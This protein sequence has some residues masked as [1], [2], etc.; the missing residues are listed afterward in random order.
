MGRTACTEPQCLYKCAVN[1]TFFME[2]ITVGILLQKLKT[3]LKRTDN[4]LPYVTDYTI[5]SLLLK[6]FRYYDYLK[7]FRGVKYL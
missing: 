4:D 3:F 1:V 2:N 7:K 5:C 6:I